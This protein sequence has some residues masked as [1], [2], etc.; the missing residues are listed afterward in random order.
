MWTYNMPHDFDAL[1]KQAMQTG[2]RKNW[3]DKFHPPKGLPHFQL[4]REGSKTLHVE[5][6]QGKYIK[7]RTSKKDG[8]H[9]TYVYDLANFLKEFGLDKNARKVLGLSKESYC[10]SNENLLGVA[11]EIN[12]A[13]LYWCDPKDGVDIEN[14]QWGKMSEKQKALLGERNAFDS[15][16]TRLLTERF[17]E[18]LAEQGIEPR[19]FNSLAS[20]S[21]EHALRTIPIE[22]LKPFADE[23]FFPSYSFNTVIELEPDPKSPTFARDYNAKQDALDALKDFRLKLITDWYRSVRGAIF[24]LYEKGLISEQTEV[25]LIAAYSSIMVLLEDMTYG[26]WKHVV[27]KDAYPNTEFGKNHRLLDHVLPF[28]GELGSPQRSRSERPDIFYGVYHVLT[29]YS[30]SESYKV[31]NHNRHVTEMLYPETFNLFENYLSL[32]EIENL[33]ELGKYVEILDGYEFVHSTETPLAF[34]FKD[35]IGNNMKLKAHYKS[36]H[37]E[38]GEYIFKQLSN[39]LYGL[40]LQT[41]GEK[42]GALFNPVLGSYITALIRI[43]MTR[44]G[45]KYFEE[46]TSE[47]TDAVIGKMKKGVTDEELKADG[48]EIKNRFDQKESF[49]FVRN[50]LTIDEDGFFTQSRGALKKR[51]DESI[52]E[53][54]LEKTDYKFVLNPIYKNKQHYGWYLEF[55]VP[56]KR[57]TRME[58]LIQKKRKEVGSFHPD[59]RHIKIEDVGRNFEEITGDKIQ[60]SVIKSTPL[61]DESLEN[62]DADLAESPMFYEDSGSKTHMAFVRWRHQIEIEELLRSNDLS[63]FRNEQNA[64][65]VRKPLTFSR[66][67]IEPTNHRRV[68][69]LSPSVERTFTNQDFVQSRNRVSKPLR[70]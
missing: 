66:P 44:A 55:E 40:T 10:L 43:K 29:Q 53:K 41:V 58:G 56:M 48:L 22:L 20:V 45:R 46:I 52:L 47:L 64:L 3:I 59:T 63:V 11:F 14:I 5:F 21:K 51:D 31:Q 9:R 25:D 13:T 33:R 37:D 17:I 49:I 1:I 69:Q 30:G 7:I 34:P 68:R 8:G 61:L 15:K 67:K 42:A 70:V 27:G 57:T 26:T 39:C 36:Q 38:L 2:S 16:L 28:S 12:G 24:K 18:I 4:R 62:R 23:V 19:S 35:Y 54:R 32:P 50:G 60:T 6:I 65:S